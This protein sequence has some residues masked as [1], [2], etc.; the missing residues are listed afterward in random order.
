MRFWRIENMDDYTHEDPPVRQTELLALVDSLP[1]LE[2]HIL[3]RVFFGGAPL[4][5]AG[6]EVGLDPDAAGVIRDRALGRLR[7]NM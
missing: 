6:R 3:E 1:R 4:S 7:G 2:R 5:V